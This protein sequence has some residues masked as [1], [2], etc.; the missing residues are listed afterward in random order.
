MER[1]Q[2]FSPE[3][4]RR[5]RTYVYRLID[6]RNGDTFYVGKGQGNRVFA[7]IHAESDLDGDELDNKMERIRAIRL[8]GFEVGHVIH[9][10]G[11]NQKAAL[12]VE[13]ALLD[14]YPGLTNVA[15]GVGSSERGAMHAREILHQYGADPAV[16]RHKALLINVNR[17]ALEVSLYEATR[18]AW[19]ISKARATQAEVVLATVHGV[20]RGAFVAEKWLPAD[21]EHFP[22]R[23]PIP[24]RLG[25]VGR[26]APPEITRLYEGKRVPDKYRKRGAAN[27]IRYTW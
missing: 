5:L 4:S 27:P 19:R 10:H 2:K 26:D 21:P 6:P 13:A 3:V 7:H 14:A 12:E 25:F 17:S 11:M 24:G 16:F 22:G 20:I 1:Q 18:Y 15:G 23:R 9:R 8:A